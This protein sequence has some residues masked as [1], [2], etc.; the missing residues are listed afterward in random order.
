LETRSVQAV[1]QPAIMRYAGAESARL[2]REKQ[3]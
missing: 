2:V 3:A 1:S